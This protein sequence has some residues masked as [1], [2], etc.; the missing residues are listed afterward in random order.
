[1]VG[2]DVGLTISVAQ[3]V[4][5]G[6]CRVLGGLTDLAVMHALNAV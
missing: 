5:G 2:V 3:H 6:L 4:L 1:V